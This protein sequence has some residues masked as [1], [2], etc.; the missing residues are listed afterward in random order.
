VAVSPGAGTVFV[1][2]TSRVAPAL[3]Y[4]TAANDAATGARR[5]VSRYSGPPGHADSA[6][7]VA[8]SPDGATVFVTGSSRAGPTGATSGLDY[9]TVAYDA[10]TGAQRWASRYNGPANGDDGASS[11]AVSPGGATVFVTGISQG[12]ASG[13]DYATV[14]YDAAT[15][16]LRWVRRYNGPRTRTT[17]PWRWPQA[18]AGAACSSP[19]R[20]P[21]PVRAWTTSRSPTTPPPAPSGGPAATTPPP[22]AL[23]LPAR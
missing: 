21:A 19:A 15:G 22:I 4:A 14:A 13:S 5:W 18:R 6:R 17:S 11:V 9:A 23:T 8:V 2:G 1:T 3:D 12:A 7:S 16:A 10:A 20:A